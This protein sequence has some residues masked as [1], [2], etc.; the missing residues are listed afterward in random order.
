MKVRMKFTLFFSLLVVLLTLTCFIAAASSDAR[1]Q[2]YLY[3]EHHG[4]EK[5]IAKEFELW[6]DYYHNHNMRHL[7]V[8]KPYYTAE[9]LNLWMQ[10]DNDEILDAVYDDW[11]GTLA[12]NPSY[13]EFFKRIKRECPETIFHGT[14]VGHQYQT[15]GQRFL[16][17]LAE[18]GLE[19]TEQYLLAQEA[20]EQGR[21]F[22]SAND[23]AYRVQMMVQNFIRE[24]ESLSGESIM[25][26]YGSAHTGLDT[27]ILPS[28]PS[29]ANQLHK[30][31]GDAV[32]SED[33]SW[34]LNVP[35]RIDIISVDGKEYEAAYFGKVDISSFSKNYLYR[36]FWRLENAYDDLKHK[37]KT[38]DVLPY[39]NYPM[40]IE[41]GQVFVIDYTTPNGSVERKYYRSD[42]LI[43]NGLPSTEEFILE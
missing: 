23:H 1:G 43:W 22:Y 36:E 12:H 20:I 13:K 35:D 3:G 39:S 16:R 38:N 24:F 14:D 31:Y 15:I 2:I 33:L 6:Y 9:F 37:R 7:F 26:I 25:G 5:I 34:L 42:G 27:M 10:A 21:R 8:E 29:M 18:N 32:H 28:V 41:E 40:D 30:H 17:Y 19:D 4:V 11:I